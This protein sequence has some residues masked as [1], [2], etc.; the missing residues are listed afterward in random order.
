MGEKLEGVFYLKDANG[1]YEIFRGIESLPEDMII[2]DELDEETYK[3]LPQEGTISFDI[4]ADKKAIK[5]IQ[6][7]INRSDKR[8]QREKRYKKRFNERV[9][10]ALLKGQMSIGV[11]AKYV[12]LFHPVAF[13]DYERRM[14]GN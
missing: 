4:S 6:K 2:C 10:R 13:E 5:Q 11:G 1:T 7:Q 14:P 12:H 9:R 8:N 3:I